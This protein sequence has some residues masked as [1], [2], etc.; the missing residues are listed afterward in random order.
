MS[1]QAAYDE[2]QALIVAGTEYDDVEFHLVKTYPDI[3]ASGMVPT[4]LRRA[5]RD[6][7]SESL[8]GERGQ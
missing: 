6:L 5:C 8:L 7:A 2:A 4:I 3:A 1:A